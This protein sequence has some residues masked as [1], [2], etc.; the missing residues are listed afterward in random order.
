MSFIIKNKP[1][2][3]AMKVNKLTHR[4]KIL[5]VAAFRIVECNIPLFV[6]E[7]EDLGNHK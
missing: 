7:R 1:H 5:F 2:K 3:L 4:Q 6:N